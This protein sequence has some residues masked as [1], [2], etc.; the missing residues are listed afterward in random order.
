M[1]CFFFP[2]VL[3]FLFP[4][5]LSPQGAHFGAGHISR[6]GDGLSAGVQP[7][8]LREPSCGVPRPGIHIP[9]IYI[10]VY[11]YAKKC[12]SSTTG[13]FFFFLTASRPVFLPEYVS[14][15]VGG[16]NQSIGVKNRRIAVSHIYIYHYV[17]YFTRNM[18]LLVVRVT[19]RPL[20]IRSSSRV[21]R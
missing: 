15:S 10:L 12:Y 17:L 8:G 4:P 16:K 3:F 14:F 11:I 1:F 13:L 6:D 18:R 21:G 9:G 7:R 20:S 2:A 19:R 5:L